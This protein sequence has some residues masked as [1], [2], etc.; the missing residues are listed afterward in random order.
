MSAI[1]I[2]GGM[3]PQASAK[4][5]ELIIRGTQNYISVPVDDDYPD[6]VLLNI[7]IPNFISNKD[8]L[9]EARQVLIERTKL[10]EKAGCTINGIACNT[11]HILLPEL[12]ATTSVPFLA[13]PQLVAE[14]IKSAGFRRVGLL[15]TP[16]TLGSPIYD[17]ALDGIAELIRPNA[18]FAK[19]I[20]QCIYKQ[21]RGA[22]TAGEQAEFKRRVAQFT[23][24]SNLEAVILGCT[25]LSLVYGESV[26]DE[27]VIDTLQLLAEGLLRAYFT[28]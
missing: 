9:P 4:L 28:S 2:L 10:L 14:Q 15:A 20:E 7:P 24:Q 5:Y 1:G 3:G 22:L 13:I 25:E 12:Q 26:G 11:V 27:R 18:V 23:K 19:Q 17:Q 21:L 8:R 6:I 16:T